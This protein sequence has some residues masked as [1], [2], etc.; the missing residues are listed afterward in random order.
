MSIFQT[1]FFTKCHFCQTCVTRYWEQSPR[2]LRLRRREARRNRF[3]RAPRPQPP[4]EGRAPARPHGEPPSWRRAAADGTAAL[5]RI[6]PVSMHGG[7]LQPCGAKDAE[8]D[9]DAGRRRVVVA[10]RWPAAAHSDPAGSGW[11]QGSRSGWPNRR[12]SI[13][14][15]VRPHRFHIAGSPQQR[16]GLPH[17]LQCNRATSAAGVRPSRDIHATAS[18]DCAQGS[19]PSAMGSDPM[20]IP[21]EK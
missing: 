11:S 6:A 3:G 21:S 9:A 20:G 10:R 16:R 17:Q 4:R 7:L 1:A 14:R 5:P 15:G 19:D 18:K 8:A 12:S 13:P 2:I